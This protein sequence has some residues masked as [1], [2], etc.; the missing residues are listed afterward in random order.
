MSRYGHHDK[1]TTGQLGTLDAV[2]ETRHPAH[3]V[4]LIAGCESHYL[5]PVVEFVVATP[6]LSELKCSVSKAEIE[7]NT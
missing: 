1:P 5:T 3:L 7:S 2:M 4:T 6:G